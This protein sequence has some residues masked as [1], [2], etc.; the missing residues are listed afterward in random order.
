MALAT[1]ALMLIGLETVTRFGFHR[2]SRIES[3]IH[4]DKEAAIAVRNGGAK[5]TILL[6]G[7]SLLL[8]GLDY[9][10]IRRE[11]A[12]YATPT[13][14]IIEQTSYLDW[15]YGI[16]RLFE[17]GA[18]PD[19]I[20]LCLSIPQL[21]ASSLRGDYSAFYLLR[22]QDLASAGWESH[23]DLTRISS[24]FFGRYSLYFA[25]RNNVR[26][27]VLNTLH[28][29]YGQVLPSLTRGPTAEI[30]DAAVLA[31]AAPRLEKLR[32]ACARWNTR[33]DFLLPP[34]FGSGEPGLIEAGRKSRT[35]VLI[36]A[37][38][39]AWGPEMFRDGFYVS[40]DGAARFT[41]GLVSALRRQP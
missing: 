27:F 38:L 28:P 23:Y 14:F 1:I 20:V 15:Y 3:R 2:I 11:M 32:E 39:N 12:P 31:G 4:A 37:P 16:Q 26:N 36:P 41:A 40:R 29:G 6:L 22:T 21:L 25:G 24:L 18:R 5:P 19:R 30:G 35:P 7:N 13:R 9:D 10:A 8:E 33:F 34:G 17:D